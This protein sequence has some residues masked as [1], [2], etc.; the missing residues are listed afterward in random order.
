MEILFDI[1]LLTL[2]SISTWLN[3]VIYRDYIRN[4]ESLNNFHESLLTEISENTE[5]LDNSSNKIDAMANG[6][7]RSLL[8]LRELLET[9]KPIKPNNWDSIK[10]AFKGPARIEVN[11]RN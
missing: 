3:L 7:D 11:E 9:T 6:L 10:E 8:A 4:K 5:K 1:I 2:L